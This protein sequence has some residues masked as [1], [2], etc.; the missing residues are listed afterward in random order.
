MLTWAHRAVRH[1]AQVLVMHLNSVHR[2]TDPEG[3]ALL[4]GETQ[5]VAAKPGKQNN[6]A[7]VAMSQHSSRQ[8]SKHLGVG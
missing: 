5:R 4:S 7:R 1:L 2:A 3:H 6:K 8:L